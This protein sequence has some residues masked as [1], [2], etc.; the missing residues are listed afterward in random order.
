M[1]SYKY[2]RFFGTVTG[3]KGGS[4]TKSG[5][6]SVHYDLRWS[7]NSVPSLQVDATLVDGS[8]RVVIRATGGIGEAPAEQRVLLDVPLADLLSVSPAEGSCN[9][10]G[11]ATALRLALRAALQAD[12]D[13]LNGKDDWA[14]Y[15]ES[16][17]TTR[18]VTRGEPMAARALEPPENF[19]AAVA[20][21][22]QAAIDAGAEINAL[23]GERHLGHLAARAFT[24]APEIRG[25]VARFPCACLAKTMPDEAYER[26]AAEL[27]AA[28]GARYVITS[29]DLD[30]CVAW[31]SDR[32]N[33]GVE[34]EA[35]RACRRAIDLAVDTAHHEAERQAKH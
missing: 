33:A 18:A 30:S 32:S 16:S 13:R 31:I 35:F 10:K 23:L 34:V 17:P 15:P 8:P 3:P 12:D 27:H 6:K 21:W 9:C 1:R 25:N 22:L 29:Q 7:D 26:K 4:V 5:M 19:R 24:D 14:P 11:R 20:E 2:D 28:V